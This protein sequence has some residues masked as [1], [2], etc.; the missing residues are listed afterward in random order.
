MKKNNQNIFFRAQGIQK[1][2]CKSCSLL[3][4]TVT[5]YY[6][7]SCFTGITIET[8]PLQETFPRVHHPIQHMPSTPHSCAVK[9]DLSL[10]TGS[11]F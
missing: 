11:K 3:S 2:I 9:I 6:L 1:V 8:L 7:I 5:K 4:P 10:K